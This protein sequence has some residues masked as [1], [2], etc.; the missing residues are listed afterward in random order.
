[1]DDKNLL[2]IFICIAISILSFLGIQFLYK[3]TPWMIGE[4]SFNEKSSI[5]HDRMLRGL[6]IIYP[7]SI[8]TIF[9]LNYN[10]IQFIDYLMLI[11]LTIV[12]FVDDKYGLNYKI[13]IIFFIFISFTYNFFISFDIEN[14]YIFKIFLNS[15][16][17]IFLIIF[18]NQ[19]DGINGLAIITFLI[20]FLFINVLNNSI[21]LYMPLIFFSL[22]YLYYNLQGKI[23][24]QGDTGSYFLAGIVYI[25]FQ[26]NHD[27]DLNILILIFFIFPLLLDLVSTTI[28]KIY[29]KQNIFAGHKDNIYQKIVTHTKNHL[30]STSFFSIIQIMFGLITI[31]LFR[32]FNFKTFTI[33]MMLIILI[34]F[35]LALYTS[36]LIQKN[37]IFRN[38]NE[39]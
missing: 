1:M 25:S 35:I 10:I 11:S 33:I 16:L 37:K 36:F 28:V 20:T 4:C 14:I 7:I 26:N 29:F 19:I 39:T 32:N 5:F 6:G 38:N 34:S 2:Y 13:K 8:T 27:N 21:L 15:G 17:L 30:I 3:I 9:F 23:G 18:F 24:I 31:F 12:G 22:P